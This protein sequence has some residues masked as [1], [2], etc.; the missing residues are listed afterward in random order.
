[1]SWRGLPLK[2]EPTY[3]EGKGNLYFFWLDLNIRDVDL[4]I[5]CI[6]CKVHSSAATVCPAYGKEK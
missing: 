5:E 4:F 1:M 3:V 2:V 6:E